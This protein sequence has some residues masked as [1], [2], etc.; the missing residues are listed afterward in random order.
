MPSTGR[1]L[2]VLGT[3]TFL[4]AA[5]STYEHLSLRKSLDLGTLT[6]HGMPIDITIETLASLLLLLVGVS[7]TAEPLKEVSWASEMRK[8]TIDAVDSRPA[9]ATLNH[10]GSIL[11]GDQQQQQ[12]Q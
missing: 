4:H 2:L 5:Y 9:F 10:R 8:R 6:E 7:L 12:Q 11:F 3:I 1:L